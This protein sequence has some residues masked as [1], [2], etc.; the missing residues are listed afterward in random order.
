MERKVNLIA[1][2]CDFNK[3]DPFELHAIMRGNYDENINFVKTLNIYTKHLRNNIL[4][5]PNFFTSIGSNQLFSH[6][7]Y[8]GIINLF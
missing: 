1:L 8:K 3:C 4:V 5:K 7:A 2:L 6:R